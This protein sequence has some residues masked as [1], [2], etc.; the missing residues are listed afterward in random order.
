MIIIPVVSGDAANIPL[1]TWCYGALA[2]GRYGATDVLSAAV[3]RYRSAQPLF[4]P[5]VSWR[6]VGDQATQ[7]GYDEG[8]V[9]V[10]MTGAQT[11]LM[12]P[13]I[14]YTLFITIQPQGQGESY[15]VARLLLRVEAPAIT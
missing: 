8:Q 5:T 2:A 3:Y 12:V 15:P 10:S 11:G 14:P 9:V 7:T 13:T 4:Q 6:V 1:Q